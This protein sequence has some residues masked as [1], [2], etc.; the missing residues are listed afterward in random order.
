MRILSLVLFATA[1]TP[2]GIYM[3]TVPY[4]DGAVDCSTDIEENFSDGYA[5][6][7]ED[8]ANSEWTYDDDFVRADRVIFFHIAPT[9]GGGA[10]LTWGDL[11]FPGVAEGDGHTFSWSEAT[12]G[13][14]T[15]EHEDG[16]VY[17][18][19]FTTDSTM[20]IHLSASVLADLAGTISMSSDSVQDY[21]ESDEWDWQD[22]DFASGQIP[23]TAY[24]EYMEDG[25][26]FAQGNGFEDDDCDGDDCELKVT[27][28]CDQVG[29]PF[30]AKH[31][32]GD[33]TL[34]YN[35]WKEDG[36]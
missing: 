29:S 11:V 22:T 5:P 23:S 35:D 4:S 25:E 6:D 9:S 19:R 31:V 17:D 20:N 10:V 14:E 12:S 32:E 1:C 30:T 28:S 3:I 21:T 15:A 26:M 16:Y 36:Q 13:F 33:D 8:A 7:E 2:S 34:L 24:L 27:E 18:A